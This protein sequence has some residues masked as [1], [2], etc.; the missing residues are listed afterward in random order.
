MTSSEQVVGR[1]TR[2]D[3]YTPAVLSPYFTW[4]GSAQL[5]SAQLLPGSHLIDLTTTPFDT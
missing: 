4:L 5:S 2:L 1:D 3:I